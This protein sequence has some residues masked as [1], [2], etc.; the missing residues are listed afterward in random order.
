MPALRGK[1]VLKDSVLSD[2]VVA[3]E[4]DTF[5]Y[6]GE[7]RERDGELPTSD[8]YILPGLV[9]EHVHGGGG[10]SFADAVELAQ[11]ERAASE[12]LRHGT[13]R[14]AAT[15]TT[16][17][18]E[19]MTRAAGVLADACEAGVIS[20]INIEGPFLSKE[21]AGAQNSAYILPPDTRAAAEVI[22]AA[23]GWAW[24]LTLAPEM[25]GSEQLI[26]YVVERGITPTFGHTHADARDARRALDIAVAKLREVG[27]SARPVAVHLFNAMR[28]VMHRA[29][30][31]VPVFIAR[32][33]R[34]D[35][36]VE[37]IADGVHLAPSL[38]RDLVDILGPE[39]ISLITD[40]ISA[41]GMED[42]TY[43]L[44]GLRVH[45]AEG[46]ARL[47]G[48]NLA[49]GTSHLLDVVRTTWRGGVELAAA[50]QM[51]SAT[52]ARVMG[53]GKIGELCEGFIADVL[54]ADE[55]L[56]PVEVYRAGELIGA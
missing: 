53:L 1:V 22:D 19:E 4:G 56:S 41:T 29:P 36:S 26:E 55:N 7:P 28:E 46:I 6:V 35:A 47:R 13:T 52:P 11:V 54:V 38:V 24:S 42:G 43:E 2:G 27:S 8:H 25:E 5:T 17:D 18:T 14:L 3:W 32:A 15:L 10:E 30:G 20:R 37:L 34:G 39:K 31:P 33:A 12:H 9:D 40:A 49:G 48:G 45:V 51:A 16:A 50:V 23:R 44:S 21:R